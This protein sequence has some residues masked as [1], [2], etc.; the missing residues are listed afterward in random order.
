MDAG[1]LG[2]NLVPKS[3]KDF[4]GKLLI[5]ACLFAYLM[6]MGSK[7]AY[8]AEIVTLQD[9]FGKGKAELSLAMTYYFIAYAIVQLALS[10]VMHKIN[11]KIYLSVTLFISSIL[12]ICLGFVPTVEYIY[13]ICTLNGFLQGIAYSGIM[14]VLSKYLPYHLLG[15]AN[16]AISS[17]AAIAGV[18]SY[19]VP[20]YFVAKGQWNMPF[21]VLG[22][23]F[24]ISVVLFYFAVTLAKKMKLNENTYEKEGSNSELSNEE[25]S[26]IEF[27]GRKKVVAFIAVMMFGTLLSNAIHYGVMNWVPDLL[28]SVFNMPQEYSILI[29]LLMPIAMF[30][31]AFVSIGVCEKHK[32][33]F[34]VAIVASIISI[35]FLILTIFFYEVNLILTLVLLVIFFIIAQF[36]RTVLGGV[37]SFKIRNQVNTGTFLAATNACASISAGVMPTI[38]GMIIDNGA[39]NSG[40]TTLF[41]C[42]LAIAVVFCVTITMVAIRYKKISFTKKE[43]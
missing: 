24:A 31:G 7:N 25:K 38:A 40:Y 39:G 21:I 10:F 2:K 34:G 19:G 35:V 32:N 1:E 36:Y 23:I 29:T 37:L 27:S 17:G 3:K 22:I 16:R 42:T 12:T 11:L 20:A 5:W 4:Y 18:I 41:I 15:Y 8:V 6:F 33:V 14:A 13:V 28:Y 9:V 30:F 43:K 26:Y